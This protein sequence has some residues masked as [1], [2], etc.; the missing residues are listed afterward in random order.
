MNQ[1]NTNQQ[2]EKVAAEKTDKKDQEITKEAAAPS[3]SWAKETKE[4]KKESASIDNNSYISGAKYIAAKYQ[5]RLFDSS[6]SL[7][8]PQL[9]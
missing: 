4:T 2:K 5:A 8:T 3:N 9:P 6:S 1:A 7:K